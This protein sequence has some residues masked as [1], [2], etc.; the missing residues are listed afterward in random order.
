MVLID[1][2][3]LLKINGLNF[4]MRMTFLIPQQ[5]LLSFISCQSKYVQWNLYSGDTLGTKESV[6]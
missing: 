3:S 4:F 5:I 6:P 1:T 2:K